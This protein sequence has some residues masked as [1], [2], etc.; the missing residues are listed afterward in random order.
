MRYQK[1]TA[2][3]VLLQNPQLQKLQQEASQQ[4]SHLLIL[5]SVLNESL[6]SSTRISSYSHGVLTLVCNQATV[7]AQ[8]RYL[9][10]IITQQ[11]KTHYEFKD[12]AKIRI[13]I[14]KLDSSQ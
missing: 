12:L 3:S 4:S 7:A 13:I 2:L 9:Q 10:H 5:R 1:P 6:R 14:G 8:L 11:L